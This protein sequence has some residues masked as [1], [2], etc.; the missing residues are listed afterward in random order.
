L[1][2]DLG[3]TGGWEGFKSGPSIFFLKMVF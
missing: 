1:G 2:A 3:M